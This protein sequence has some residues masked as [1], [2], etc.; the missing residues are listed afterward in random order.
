MGAMVHVHLHTRSI[1]HPREVGACAWGVSFGRIVDSDYTLS[2]KLESDGR[3]RHTV[4][5]RFAVSA[6]LIFLS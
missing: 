4:R 5:F 2:I 1:D 3:L 6:Q